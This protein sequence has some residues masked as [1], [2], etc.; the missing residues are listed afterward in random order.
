LKQRVITGIIFGIVV[1]TLLLSHDFGR[2]ALLILIPLFSV[3]E[4]SR[5]TN[6]AAKDWIIFFAT[7]L[8]IFYLLFTGMADP[9][10]ILVPICF[11]NLL[12]IFNLFRK[13]PFIKHRKFKSIIAALYLIAPFF[14]AYFLDLHSSS[15]FVLIGIVI[16][17]WVSDS[18]AYFVGSQIGKRKFF[19]SISPNKTWEGFYGSGMCVFIIAYVIASIT[20]FRDLSFWILLALIIW[21]AGA[22]GDLVASHVKR[23][24]NIKDSGSL[25]PGHGGFFDRFDA[26]ILVLPF[27][28]LMLQI[29]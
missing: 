24:H 10:Y 22:L 12:L 15:Y 6:F 26:F 28:L 9:N 8:G 29:F 3:I 2:L 13:Y 25:L 11:L 21:I 16:L 19:P 1:L 7:C 14:I 5:M 4:Y 17:I 20:Q 18:S 23:L 27:V